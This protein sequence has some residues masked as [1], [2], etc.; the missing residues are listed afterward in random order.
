[1]EWIVMVVE[2]SYAEIDLASHGKTHC[3]GAI[4]FCNTSVMRDPN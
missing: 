3:C 2:A 4:T 1:M